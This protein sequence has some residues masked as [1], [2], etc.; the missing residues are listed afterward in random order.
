MSALSHQYKRSIVFL[1]A[2]KNNICMNKLTDRNVLKVFKDA[3]PS[4]V[5]V[6]PSKA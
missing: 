2:V 3:K 6:F 4:D 5:K 1:L